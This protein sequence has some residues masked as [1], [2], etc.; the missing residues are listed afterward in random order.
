MPELTLAWFVLAAAATFLIDAIHFAF[1]F[2][3]RRARAKRRRR[4]LAPIDWTADPHT[5]LAH[6]AE[7]GTA[8]SAIV[9]QTDRDTPIRSLKANH[10]RTPSEPLTLDRGAP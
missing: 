4:A 10:R 1:Q 2:V 8:A 9:Q 3:A 7:A 5:C 6:V